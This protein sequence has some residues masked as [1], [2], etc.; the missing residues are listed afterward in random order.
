MEMTITH[1]VD[2]TSARGSK[3]GRV[4][5]LHSAIYTNPEA[6]TGPQQKVTG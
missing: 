5:H 6:A 2:V 4:C 1:S 3:R